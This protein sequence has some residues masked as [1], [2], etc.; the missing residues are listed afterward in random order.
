VHTEEIFG[1]ATKYDSLWFLDSA[2]HWYWNAPYTW[3]AFSRPPSYPLFIAIVHALGIRLRVAIECFQMGGYAVLVGVLRAI[4]FPRWMALSV[5][6]LLLFHPESFQ[7]N[8]YVQADTFYA[9]VLVYLVAG[10]FF[11]LATRR[12]AP[13]IGSGIALA[14]LWNTREESFLLPLIFFT[15]VV[16]A[17]Y[18]QI[19]SDG[20]NE[21]KIFAPILA[22]FVTAAFLIIA[23]YTVNYRTFGTFRKS[24]TTE[25]GLSAAYRALLRIKPTHP[26]RFVS[27]SREACEIACTVSPTFAQLKPFFDSDV[28]GWQG[29]EVPNEIGTVL[30]VWALRQMADRAGAYKDSQTSANFYLRIAKEINLACDQKRIPSRFVLSALVDPN[31]MASIRYVPKSFA[32]IWHLFFLSYKISPDREDAVLSSS[33]RTLYDEMAG[34]T[35]SLTRLGTLRIV[36]WAF[37]FGDPITIIAHDLGGGEIDSAISTFG[38]RADVVKQFAAEGEVPLKNEFGLP[39]TIR[40]KGDPAGKLIFITQSG[41]KF[42]GSTQSI[43]ASQAPTE[44]GAAQAEPLRCH[45][46]AQ[47]YAPASSALSQSFEAIIGKYYRYIMR[48]LT[49]AAVTAAFVLVFNYRSWRLRDPINALL[50]LVASIIIARVQLFTF[51]NAIAWPGIEP[52]FLFPVMSLYALFLVLLVYQAARVRAALE[53]S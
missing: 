48:V 11:T 19:R 6:A 18:F 36:G 24:D 27:I 28:G 21:K 25:P 45:I 10:I 17:V 22:M 51:I 23:V 44:N 16:L 47:E 42:I 29:H 12:L 14:V 32:D 30:F 9:A 37:R 20:G 26:Q 35:A 50:V 52:R 31:T 8:N 2:K 13:A 39:L 5:F 3:T 49:C 53:A 41:R 15:Y 43:L 46:F 33:E 40:R 4:R 34:R 38:E 1:S 7:R